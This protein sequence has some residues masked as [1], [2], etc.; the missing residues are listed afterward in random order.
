[1]ITPPE[2]DEYGTYYEKYISKV[3]GSDVV[4]L[5]LSQVEEL[6]FIVEQMTEETAAEPYA[7]NKWT[8]KQLLGHINDTEKIMFFRALCVAR[9]EQQSLPGFDQD[10][11]VNAADF[12]EVPLIDLMEDF[13]HIRHS[14]VY[15]LK[16]LSA[17]A[18]IRKGTINGHPTSA[19]SLLY[20]ILGHFEHH[21]DVLKGIS[22][23]YPANE[24]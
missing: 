18:S 6:R 17:D 12:N 5:L 20:I 11:Y 24:S 14:I 19:R 15:F 22:Q 4:E 3:R 8:Y 16:N 7:P 21:L 10:D 13:E 2:E 9:N 1:M 23:T